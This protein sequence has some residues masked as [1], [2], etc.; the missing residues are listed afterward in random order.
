MDGL[1]A[2]HSCTL[3]LRDPTKKE[4]RLDEDQLDAELFEATALK[5]KWTLGG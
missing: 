4:E 5:K 2:A 3:A 1:E